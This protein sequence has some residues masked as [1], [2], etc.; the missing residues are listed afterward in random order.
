MEL[1]L[2]YAVYLRHILAAVVLQLFSAQEEGEWKLSDMH[3][4]QMLRF[5]FLWTNRKQ[6][7][8]THLLPG[9]NVDMERR[10]ERGNKLML[11]PRRERRLCIEDTQWRSVAAVYFWRLLPPTL[12][13]KC[14]PL[15]RFSFFFFLHLSHWYTVCSYQR[16]NKCADFVLCSPPPSCIHPLHWPSQCSPDTG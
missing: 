14:H 4:K 12:H 1:H 3:T 7:T 16:H 13:P 2:E 9:Y 15:L 5:I 6:H 8:H 11:L 10:G